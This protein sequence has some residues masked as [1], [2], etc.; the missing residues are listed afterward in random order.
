MPSL[1]KN[2]GR[3]SQKAL[4]G[5]L[6]KLAAEAVDITPDGTPITREQKL[7]QLIWNQALGW[8]EEVRD[9]EGNRKEIKH[10]PVG[11]CQQYLFERI[12]GKAPQAVPDEH[13]GMKAADKVRELAKD[14]INQMATAAVGKGGPPKYKPKG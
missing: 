12:E 3:L 10:Q 6:K 11:W 13:T 2:I 7:A 5:E 1:A 8:T 4:T 9:D 14:R